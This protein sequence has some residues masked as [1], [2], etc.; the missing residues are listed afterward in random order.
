MVCMCVYVCVC[1]CV[2]NVR[3]VILYMASL[4]PLV[5]L[6]LRYRSRCITTALKPGVTGHDGHCRKEQ[7]HSSQSHAFIGHSTLTL[8]VTLH[9]CR[10]Q[11]WSH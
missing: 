4:V 9:Y 7:S 1:V 3:R 5:S 2:I 6:L 11:T 10:S 8:Q